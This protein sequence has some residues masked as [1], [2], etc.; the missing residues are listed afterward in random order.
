VDAIFVY[1]NLR[2]AG[3]ENDAL[4]FDE[5]KSYAAFVMYRGLP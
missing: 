3:D 5:T 1:V 4:V 2:L